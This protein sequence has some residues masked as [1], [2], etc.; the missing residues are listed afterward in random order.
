M[1]S[2]YSCLDGSLPAPQP[3]Q[4][5]AIRD[6]RQKAGGAVIFYGAEDVRT[7]A[8]QPFIRLKLARLKETGLDGVI[9]YRLQQFRYG[10]Q[11]NFDLL[12]SIL[13]LGLEVLFACEDLSIRNRE[14]F[15]QWFPFLA[16]VD[17]GLRRDQGAD[18]QRFV[19]EVD[20]D[21]VACS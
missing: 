6:R 4:H 19:Q 10:S 9:F 8:T 5:L 11:F 7:L 20:L 18:W 2:F 15:Q 17:Y 21:A 1:K 14:E 13:D 12:L 16:A 3:I